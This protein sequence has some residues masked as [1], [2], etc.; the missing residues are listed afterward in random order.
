M[1][2]EQRKVGI[3]DVTCVTFWLLSAISFVNQRDPLW[4]G[5]ATCGFEP[6]SSFR[7]DGWANRNVS[8]NGTR[9]TALLALHKN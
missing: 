5:L 9:T 4:I 6:H 3:R 8:R 7:A 1:E 2:L